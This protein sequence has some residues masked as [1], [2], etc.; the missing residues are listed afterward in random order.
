M[1][2]APRIAFTLATLTTLASSTAALSA[3]RWYELAPTVGLR[4]GADLHSDIPATP[5]AEADPSVA[6]GLTFDVGL[7][8]DTW[9]E[10]FFERQTLEFHADP[11]IFGTDRFDVTIDYLQFGASYGPPRNGL[12]GFVTVSAGLTHFGAD[13]ADVS[14]SVAFS[15]SIG[16]GF[17]VPVND[18]L[19]FRLDVRGYGTLSGAELQVTCGPGCIVR[20][21]GGGWYQMGA[22]AGL[23]IRL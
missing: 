19:G 8:Q 13:G 3:E 9:L 10:T 12:R 17:Q 15:G 22:R 11:A 16:G 7:S 21:D 14:S 6:F 18:R 20:F 2:T 23:A 1:N 5:P 4:G